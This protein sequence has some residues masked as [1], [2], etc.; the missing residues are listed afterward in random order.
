MTINVTPI[1]KLTTLTTP[2]FQLGTA[3]AAGDALTA[4]ASNSTLLAFDTTIPTATS[5]VSTTGSATT[6]PRRDHA[7]ATMGALTTVHSGSRLASAGA[8][9]QAI[10]GIGFAP[11]GI[12]G[13]AMRNSSSIGCWS[14]ADDSAVDVSMRMVSNGDLSQSSSYFI[15]ADGGT[16]WLFAVL[17]SLDSDGATLT[18]TKGAS[19]LDVYY[20]LLFWR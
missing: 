8:G 12:V 5:T 10:T 19:G 1:P 7:H 2:A 9:V 17:T 13:V 20:Y 18:W 14:F 3:N 16:D 15:T 6:A 11:T 4:V